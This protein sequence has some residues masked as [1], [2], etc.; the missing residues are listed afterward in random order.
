MMPHWNF[1]TPVP[2][3]RSQPF[4]TNPS[5]Q[6]PHWAVPFLRGI[7]IL[8]FAIQAA[9]KETVGWSDQIKTKR[10]EAKFG[11]PSNHPHQFEQIHIYQKNW[12]SQ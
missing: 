11:Y 2:C 7:L 1:R 4:S 12:F 3:R 6:S 5:S 9:I 10:K 8:Y